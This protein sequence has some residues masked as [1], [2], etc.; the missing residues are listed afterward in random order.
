MMVKRSFFSPLLVT[1]LSMITTL[2]GP[3]DPRKVDFSPLENVALEEL[4]ETNTPGAA[5]AII[6]GD[7]VVFAKGFGVSSV[8]TG[9]PV[10]PDM[11]F[12]VGSVT[13]VFTASVLT[14]LSE[15][16]KIKLDH[17]V[18]EYV[19]GL[20]S[21]LSRITAHQLMTHTAGIRDEALSYGPHDES[22]IAF[23]VRSWKDDYF[24]TDPGRIFSYSNPGFTLAGFLIEELGGKPYVE[25]MIERLFKPL[26]MSSTTFR[27][28]MAMTY[29]LSQGHQVLSDGKPTVVRPFTDDAGYWP[30]GFVFSSVND[31]SRFAIAFM[32][33]GKME[34]KQVL[35]P[36]VITKL[37]T[38]YTP[39]YGYPDA[40]YYGYG[41]MVHDYRGVRVVE[42]SG[43]IQGFGCLLKMA[44]DQRVAVIIL[45]NRTGAMLSQTAEKAFELMLPLTPKSK[46][47]PEPALLMAESEL[48]K[49][50][51][52]YYHPPVSIEISAKEGK[53]F[54]KAFGTEV[55]ITKLGDNRFSFVSPIDSQVQEFVTIPGTDGKIEYLHNSLRA[56]KRISKEKVNAVAARR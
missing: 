2:A 14:T 15:E 37:S 55:P 36:T 4:K 28:T 17:R 11:L 32:N 47:K 22:A 50:V 9:S 23:S 43:S 30:A 31:L 56:L 20:S 25:Q 26:G 34:A 3:S 5:V 53:L 48:D 19:S 6:S 24:L 16:G 29:P 46:D 8:E 39:V 18:G 1:V 45:A 49:Y 10:T 52:T 21:G 51:G 38:R 44:P 12:R 35:T 41:L 7:R 40:R 27:P 42:H 54:L 33:G 13:K